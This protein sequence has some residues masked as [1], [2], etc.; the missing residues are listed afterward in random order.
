MSQLVSYT[1]RFVDKLS[2]VTDSMNISGSLSIKTNGIGGS[3]GGSFVD[4]N[5]F[6]DSDLNF[7]IQVKVI[8]Q[9]VICKD[10]LL[11]QPLP[12]LKP[13]DFTNVFGKPGIVTCPINAVVTDR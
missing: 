2:D 11:F 6:K 12:N 9:K 4:T 10:N 1:S 3:G 13:A 7:F 5:K 8:N